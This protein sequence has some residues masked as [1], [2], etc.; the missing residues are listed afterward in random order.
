MLIIKYFIL[1]R[2]NCPNPYI[3]FPLFIKKWSLN[4]FLDYTQSAQGSI[5]DELNHLVNISKHLN[6]P[7]LVLVGGLDKPHIFSTMLLRHPFFWSLIF[8]NL[9]IS[10][11]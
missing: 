8:C 5:V 6:T 2:D 3:K 4:I 1:G 9:S 10:Q 7:T 11:T